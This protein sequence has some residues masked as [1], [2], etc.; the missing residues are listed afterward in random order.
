M[1]VTISGHPGSGTSTLVSGICQEL[2]WNSLNGGDIFRMEAKKR[3]LSLSE[4]E[5]LCADDPKVDESLDLELRQQM[6]K[7]SGVEVIESRLSGWWAYNLELDCVRIWLHADEK[8]RAERVMSREST[9]LSI[10]MHENK[11]RSE[12]DR[13]RFNKMYGIDIEDMAPYTHII[14]VSDLD[15]SQVLS[16]VLSIL[17]EK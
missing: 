11:A 16:N 3:N 14:D 1:R 15:A 2:E 8:T 12:V 6:T 7:S 17:E 13:R 10:A 5:K 4:F 9:S